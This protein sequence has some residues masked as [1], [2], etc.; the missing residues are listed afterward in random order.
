MGSFTDAFCPY[1]QQLLILPHL[2]PV[3]NP[4]FVE[5]FSFQEILHFMGLQ[6]LNKRNFWRRDGR[7]AGGDAIRCE[8]FMG[9]W[10]RMM[11]VWGCFITRDCFKF[12]SEDETPITLWIHSLLLVWSIICWNLTNTWGCISGELSE[13]ITMGVV[14][15]YGVIGTATPICFTP[16][17]FL[18][19]HHDSWVAHLCQC[20][21]HMVHLS[22]P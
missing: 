13:Y 5:H 7:Q 9:W 15:I 22:I 11:V 16:A 19:T 6:N 17:A 21:R 18:S 12:K 14:A 8:T 3:C 1:D 20:N 4:F 10:S 2:Y